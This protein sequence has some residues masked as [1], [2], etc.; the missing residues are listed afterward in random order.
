M[1]EL[2][3]VKSI[4][5]YSFAFLVIIFSIIIIFANRILYSL[6]SAVIVFFCTGGIFFALGADYNAVVQIAVYGVAVPI[7]FLFAIM[8]TSQKENKTVYL[9]YAPRFFISF[10][11]VSLLFMILWYSFNLAI[12]MNK[13]AGNFLSFNPSNFGSFNSVVAVANGIYINYNLA[14][15]VFA[16]IVAIAVTGFSVFNIV[17]EKRDVK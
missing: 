4:T 1:S 6:L 3:I 7:I 11:S 15:I 5:F 13:L 17:K 14:F 2:D 10:I 8:F 12:N 16:F 9:S